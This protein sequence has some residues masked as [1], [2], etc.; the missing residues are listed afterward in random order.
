ML[1]GK[2]LQDPLL[3]GWWSQD[4]LGLDCR[5]WS[6][7]SHAVDAVAEAVDATS[8]PVHGPGGHS[9]ESTVR[10]VVVKLAS[11]HRSFVSSV[12]MDRFGMFGAWV[13][14]MQTLLQT[15][16][17]LLVT[18][19]L[20]DGG[21]NAALNFTCNSVYAV[22][23]A[24]FLYCY[25]WMAQRPAR[26]YMLG[27]SLY[28]VGYLGFAG[29]YWPGTSAAFAGTL[30]ALGAGLFLLGS[31]AL[32]V[33]T[34]PCIAAGGFSPRL[35]SLPAALFWGSLAF[36][37]GS[38]LFLADAFGAGS[39]VSTNVGLWVFLLGRALFVRG[40]QTACCDACFRDGEARNQAQSLSGGSAAVDV[41]ADVADCC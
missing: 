14:F 23:Y 33:A 32:L 6:W 21:A 40:S 19:S 34:K 24:S 41:T 37:V 27:V 3:S 11:A 36:L 39:A 1:T 18:C 35:E 38:L 30:Y 8:F 17:A 22:L 12:W 26:S 10:S 9:G 25:V 29:M 4:Q 28:F 13:C 20:L 2:S 5:T 7:V 31:V 15:V 16:S